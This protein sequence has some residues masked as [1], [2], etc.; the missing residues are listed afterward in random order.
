MRVW[1]LIL[2]ALTAGGAWAQSVVDMGPVMVGMKRGEIGADVAGVA[3]TAGTSA[4]EGTVAGEIGTSMRRMLD[5]KME[6]TF[7]PDKWIK[8]VGVNPDQLIKMLP[9]AHY[10]SYIFD[11]TSK[12]PIKNGLPADINIS[13]FKVHV[14]NPTSNPNVARLQGGMLCQL[15][16]NG[17]GWQL[18]DPDGNTY[19]NEDYGCAQVVFHHSPAYWGPVMGKL[20]E[21]YHKHFGQQREENL[22]D[23]RGHLQ[24]LAASISSPEQFVA[25]FEDEKV[26]ALYW[27]LFD[28][29]KA[30]LRISSEAFNELFVVLRDISLAETLVMGVGDRGLKSVGMLYKI[31]NTVPFPNLESLLEMLKHLWASIHGVPHIDIGW[32]QQDVRISIIT[33]YHN[34]QFVEV[35]KIFV[36]PKEAA[37]NWHPTFIEASQYRS[38][39]SIPRKRADNMHAMHEDDPGR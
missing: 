21:W 29:F 23:I 38:V 17:K 1:I 5:G 15:R 18:T 33:R 27:K 34:E 35:V 10:F 20:K 4:R 12:L 22:E 2:I 31:G 36:T 24:S 37:M 39:L 16:G 8:F 13:P 9:F 32:P 14:G 26:L 19:T 7:I 28:R 3:I 30:N 11:F 6:I 25:T